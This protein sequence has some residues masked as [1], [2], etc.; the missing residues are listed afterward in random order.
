MEDPLGINRF[1]LFLRAPSLPWQARDFMG[2]LGFLGALAAIAL[3]CAVPVAGVHYRGLAVRAHSGQPYPTE[4]WRLRHAWIALCCI[5]SASLFALYAAGSVDVMAA[6]AGGW[7]IDATHSQLGRVT[8]IE[9]LLTISLLLPFGAVAASRQ[10]LW[11][12]AQWSVVKSCAVALAL[13]LVFR[14]PLLMAWT[15]RPDSMQQLALDD[16]LWQMIGT[17]RDQ[18]GMITALW[19]VGITAPVVEEFVFRGILLRSFAAHI[20]PGWANLVQAALFSA[21]HMNLKAAVLLFVFGLVL[22]TLARRSG[23]LLA[24]MIMHAAFNLTA[25]LLLL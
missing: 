1:A 21:M 7:A 25:A 24:P 17:V 14:L 6:N 22:G 10:T 13:A 23:S 4:G 15:S 11:G 3:I 8:L 12:D 19:V 18:Y 16:A 5:G 2:L 9:S 20:S